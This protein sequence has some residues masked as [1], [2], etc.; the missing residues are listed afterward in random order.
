MY[1]SSQIICLSG[2]IERNDS[3]HFSQQ[4]ICGVD[5]DMYVINK[6]KHSIYCYTQAILSSK[7]S[8]QCLSDLGIKPRLIRCLQPIALTVKNDRKLNWIVGR[9]M[10]IDISIEV[11][12]ALIYIICFFESIIINYQ[13]SH[14]IYPCY[15][16]IIESIS[17][18]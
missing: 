7:Y 1:Y 14:H 13:P 18:I 5:L 12:L 8:Q 11:F 10:D 2:L 6:S 3:S 4:I 15:N 16:A 17:G 9:Y